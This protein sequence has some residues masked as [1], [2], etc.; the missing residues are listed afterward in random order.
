MVTFLAPT[1]LEVIP[2]FPRATRTTR[3]PGDQSRTH[4]MSRKALKLERIAAD[5][6]V[7]HSEIVEK[8]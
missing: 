5:A 2:E 1:K 7:R 8:E 6:G 4:R 3:C